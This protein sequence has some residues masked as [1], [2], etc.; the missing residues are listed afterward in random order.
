MLVNIDLH[1]HSTASDGILSPS[2]LVQASRD[3]GLGA[4]A[5]TDHD[6][7]DGLVEALRAGEEFGIEVVPGIE[8]NTDLPR[9]HEEVHI[10]GYFLRWENPAFQGRLRELRA[11][12][13]RRALKRIEQLRT[14]GLPIS[15]EQVQSLAEGPVGTP[16][17]ALALVQIR[18]VGSVAEAR[19]RYLQ[20]GA[21]GYAPREPFSAVEA[22]QLIRDVGGT[23]VLA[24][25]ASI[26]KLDALL[27]TLKS[28]GLTGL[29]V[30]YG[31]YDDEVISHL[32]ALAHDFGLV[33]TGGSDFHGAGI[34]PTPLGKRQVPPEALEELRVL[35]H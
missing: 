5:L 35:A 27:P 20:H 4:I 32:L 15:W 18:A 14:I 3:A 24:H 16:H 2:A 10:L 8:I 29:E 12:R 25:P 30:Y 7:T 23:S 33:P 21:P 13:E 17:I 19:T 28:V 9:N 26:Q 6:T 1:T 34:Q 31:E 11:A 22:I